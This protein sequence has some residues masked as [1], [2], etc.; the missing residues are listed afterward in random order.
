M[1]PHKKM[2]RGKLK[3]RR[4]GTLKVY[5][6]WLELLFDCRT[7]LRSGWGNLNDS[8]GSRLWRGISLAFR[9]AGL[10]LREECAR[11]E[12][13]GSLYSRCLWR[14]CRRTD[15]ITGDGGRKCVL[16]EQTAAERFSWAWLRKALSNCREYLAQVPS[17]AFSRRFEETCNLRP[18]QP[19]LPSR[20]T[21][22][23]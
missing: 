18:L 14:W 12:E 15:W 4:N 8:W 16:P 17:R 19:H 11:E 21:L 1:F 9:S 10:I 22:L 6:I 20:V 5:D 2:I 23:A 7:F 13:E 3:D